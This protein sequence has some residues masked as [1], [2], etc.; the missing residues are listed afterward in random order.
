M[1]SALHQITISA[2][3]HTRGIRG[4]ASCFGYFVRTHVLHRYPLH[5]DAA[6]TPTSGLWTHVDWPG[7][8]RRFTRGVSASI[9]GQR[10]RQGHR[11]A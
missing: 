5:N 1:S 11:G 9:D 8:A 7:S 3:P 2:G 4:F 10:H 6:H